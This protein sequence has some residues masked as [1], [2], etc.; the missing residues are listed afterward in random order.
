MPQSRCAPLPSIRAIS[1]SER[2]ITDS[3]SAAAEANASEGSSTVGAVSP[4]SRSIPQR[5]RHVGV[6]CS[7]S[8]A[9]TSVV[10]SPSNT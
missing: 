10:S 8:A 7:M 1:K 2:K 4:P 5:C 3:P 9:V 6:G